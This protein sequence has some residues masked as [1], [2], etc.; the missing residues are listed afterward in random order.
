MALINIIVGLI[1]AKRRTFAQVPER[2][3]EQ[4]RADF[5]CSGL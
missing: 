1:I 3:K 4:V 5:V 2:D